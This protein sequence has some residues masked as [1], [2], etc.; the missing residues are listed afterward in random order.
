MYDFLRGSVAA[1]DTAGGLTLEVGGVGYRLRISEQTRRRIPLD[2]SAVL[3]HVRLVVRED[4]L[5]LYGFH[6][7]AER[8]AFDLLTGVQQVGPLVAMAVLSELGVDALR[9]ALLTRD[10]QA[11]RQVKGIGPKLAERLAV[12]LADKAERIPPPKGGAPAAATTPAGDAA[13]EAQRA[14]VVLGFGQREAA[15]AVAAAQQPGMGAEHLLRAA[16]ARLR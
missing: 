14:L 2:G 5:L 16:L 6:D 8:A 15:E 4:D 7:V 3:V 11:L 1:L 9:R 13:E 10:V 12:E